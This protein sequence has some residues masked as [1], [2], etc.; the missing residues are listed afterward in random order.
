MKK[1]SLL[2]SALLAFM[3]F[4]FAGFM[5]A[6]RAETLARLPIN[7]RSAAVERQNNLIL[8]HI[9]SFDIRQP[10]LRSV[11]VAIRFHSENQTALTFVRLYPNTD[12]P[13]AGQKLVQSFGLTNTAAPAPVFL[14]HLS[15]QGIQFSGYVLVDDQGMQQVG[16][17]IRETAPKANISGDDQVLQASCAA[18]TSAQSAPLPSFN[19]PAFSAHLNTNLAFDEIL[20]EW[21][22][23]VTADPPLRCELAAQ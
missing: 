19:W 18:L 21:D 14:R 22:R 6:A 2:L 23:L 9:D 15:D 7:I 13:K 11:W 10:V 4:A 16:E 12:D 5:M 3:V 20:V 17:W 1:I 8:V